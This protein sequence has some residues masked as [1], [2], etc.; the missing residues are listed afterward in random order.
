MEIAAGDRSTGLSLWRPDLNW[1]D[2]LATGPQAALL[3]KKYWV[4]GLGHLGQ[5]YL[6]NISLLPYTDPNQVLILLQDSDRIVKANWSAGL[7]TFKKSL[8]HYKTRWCSRWLEQRGFRTLLTERRFDDATRRAAEEPFVALCGFDTAA[9][10]LPLQDAGFDL[11]VEAGLGGNLAMFDRA[12]LH[13][14]PNAQRS[15]KEIWGAPD[16]EDAEANPIILSILRNQ[17]KDPCGIV[18]ITI[19][20]KAVSASFV[21]AC[22]GALA[23]SEILRGLHDGTRYE[24]ICF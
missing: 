18:P 23:I 6:W 11:I 12:T 3:P 4:L 21:G 19:A 24:K 10:R 5:A 14:F 15:P 22:T 16:Q 1:L 20:R 8:G 17:L 13:T 9:S 7:L 2:P